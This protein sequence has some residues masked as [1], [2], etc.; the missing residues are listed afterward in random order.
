MDEMNKLHKMLLDAGIN[1][2]FMPMNTSIFGENAL[3][4]RIYRDDTFQK[5]LD[6]VVFHDF[7]HGNQLGLLETYRLGNCDGYETAEQVFN[8]WMKKFFS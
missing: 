4:I 7:S 2:I 1:H 3:Q 8:G 5:E 6:D